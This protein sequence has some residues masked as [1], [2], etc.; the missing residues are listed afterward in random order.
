[1][2]ISVLLFP[3]MNV[4]LVIVHSTRLQLARFHAHSS[5]SPLLILLLSQPRSL[6]WVEE[7]EEE[8]EED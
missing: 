4:T 7:E 3:H 8:E 5:S 2:E 6:R 1:M